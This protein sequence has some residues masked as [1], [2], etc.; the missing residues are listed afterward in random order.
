MRRRGMRKLLIRQA[1]NLGKTDA[2]FIRIAVA[3]DLFGFIAATTVAAA[4]LS[5]RLIR[6]YVV[7]RRM[8]LDH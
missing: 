5:L 3:G 6:R 2:I 7:Q 1:R 8:E 4:E